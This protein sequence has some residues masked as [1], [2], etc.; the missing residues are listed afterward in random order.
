MFAA[1]IPKF[2]SVVDSPAQNFRQN[3]ITDY[4]HEYLSNYPT[5]S[6]SS[7]EI[8]VLDNGLTFAAA[9]AFLS[10]YSLVNTLPFA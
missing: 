1:T 8:A 9:S 6:T 2:V 7:N 4:Q 10:P 5:F 3:V